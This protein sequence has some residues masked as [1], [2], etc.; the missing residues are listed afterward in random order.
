MIKQEEVL[1]IGQFGKPHGIKGEISLITNS[2]VFDDSDDPYI[3]CD[4]NGILVPFF[5]EEYRYKSE[6]VILV[7]LEN[8]DSDEAVREFTNRDVFY[9]LDEMGE[10]NDLI[11]D[12]TWDSFIGFQVTDEKHGPLGMITGVDESTMNVLLQIRQD[13]KEI[14][15]PAVEEIITAADHTEKQLTVSVPE[16]LLDL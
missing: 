9:P 16:G 1:K 13:D 5:I 8:I 6:N 2:D 10:E 15:I 7:K 3:I 4:I 12:I 11:G 14:L